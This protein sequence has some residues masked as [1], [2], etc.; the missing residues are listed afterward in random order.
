MSNAHGKLHRQ[1]LLT[2]YAHRMR[3]APSEPERVLWQALRC[4]QLGTPF[5]R[6]VVVQGYIVDFLAPSPRLV[7]EVDGA[8]HTRQRGGD[9]RRDRALQA[10]GLTVLRLPAQVAL[11]DLRLALRLIAHALA[12]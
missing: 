3:L 4:C 5:R 1:Q 12:R 2:A 7:V 6:Q 10:A 9:K 11:S 8:Q